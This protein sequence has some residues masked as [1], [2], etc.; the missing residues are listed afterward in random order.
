MIK[1]FSV[2]IDESY[3]D[4]NHAPLYHY[5]T[6]YQFIEILE[7]NIL[8]TSPFYSQV[9]GEKIKIVS[10]TRNK[11]LDLSYY[12]P[13]LNVIIELDK[14]K[15]M[16]NYKIYPYDYFIHSG[17]ED[18]TKSD[19]NR[20]NPFEFEEMTISDIFHIDKYILSV[21]FRMESILE[22]PVGKILKILKS[23]NI[24]VYEDGKEY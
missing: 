21:N 9:G 14:N 4:S 10:L 1:D 19:I 11:N 15:L 23:K 18:K 8:K 16:K 22:P 7:S 12:K 17:K 13:Y 5:T 20:N 24:K 2:F 3:L 6:T